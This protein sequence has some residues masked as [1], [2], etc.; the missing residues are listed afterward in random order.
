MYLMIDDMTT[1][2][3]LIN[4]TFFNGYIYCWML[5]DKFKDCTYEPASFRLRPKIKTELLRQIPKYIKENSV[6]FDIGASIGVYSVRIANKVKG[7]KVYSFEPSPKN[8]DKLCKNIWNANLD[9]IVMPFDIALTN[10]NTIQDFYVSSCIYKSSLFKN[11][12]LKGT[13]IVNKIKVK[14][15][16]IDTIIEDLELE[17]PD[18]IKIDTEGSEYNIL[19][20]A[21]NLLTNKK[22]ILFIEPH[23]Q[24]RKVND[25]IIEY[26]KQFGYKVE[27]MG[28]PIRCY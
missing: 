12:A 23:G 6:I 15:Y 20:G 24:D 28:L 14:C 8:F 26:L 10:C 11:E 5:Y 21:K 16:T 19:L 7:S 9:N 2:N 13:E 17:E 18:V 1:S 22:P 3:R 4:K 25:K 27:S